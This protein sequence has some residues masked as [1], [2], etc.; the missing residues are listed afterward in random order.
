MSFEAVSIERRLSPQDLYTLAS[1]VSRAT[2]KRTGSEGHTDKGRHA[3]YS[4][5]EGKLEKIPLHL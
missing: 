2:E 5:M 3:H 1:G 4:Q